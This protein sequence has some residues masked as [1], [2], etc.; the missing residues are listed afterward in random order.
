MGVQGDALAVLAGFGIS[1]GEIEEL[2]ERVKI[3]TPRAKL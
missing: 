2:K 3:K 1:S